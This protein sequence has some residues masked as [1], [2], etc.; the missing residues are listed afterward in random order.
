MVGSS[1]RW[2][3]ITDGGDLVIRDVNWSKNMGLYKCLAHNSHGS[4]QID[5]FLYPVS[6][7]TSSPATESVWKSL[8]CNAIS[9][10]FLL[11]LMLLILV[12]KL[13]T[14]AYTVFIFYCYSLY[15]RLLWQRWFAG[16]SQEVRLQIGRG[17]VMFVVLQ[18]LF[19]NTCTVSQKREAT[20]LWAVTLSNLNRF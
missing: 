2:L 16:K 11:L 3:Q 1:C 9:Y 12:F 14:I 10:G 4:D 17:V 18:L 8:S 13:Y 20:K 15:V 19:A 5:T 7:L 6:E